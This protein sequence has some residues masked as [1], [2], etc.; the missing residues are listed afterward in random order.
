[1]EIN[2]LKIGFSLMTFIIVIVGGLINSY[3]KFLPVFII[4]SFRY[5][6]FSYCGK[7]SG[8][9][10]IEVPKRWF[11][12]FYIVSSLLSISS[13]ILMFRIILLGE[14]A[15]YALIR[16]LDLIATSNRKAGVSG[17]ALL[18]ALSLMCLQCCRRLY[19]TTY[20][21]VF[22]NSY[23]NVF[24]Y[25][26]GFIHYI[27]SILAILSEAPSLTPLSFEYKAALSIW[28]VDL[29]MVFGIMVFC[30]AWYHQFVSAK[31]LANLRKNKNGS[32]VTL[33]HG[34]PKGDL[35][36]VVSS[37]SQLC[38]VLI[39][40]ALAVIL[41]GNTAWPF[42]VVWV[43]SNQMETALLSHWWYQ[44]EFKDYPKERRAIVPLLL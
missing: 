11:Q 27:G 32:V 36:E 37:P 19:E 20:V 1:M 40:L 35:F 15:P 34:L 42:V 10:P 2:L 31:I 24:H 30:W 3:E 39:Y 6:K 16:F 4:E 8:L 38:E 25:L 7:E 44:A 9:K 43:L 23:M 29:F 13:L 33:K 41:R 17:T 26:V 28:D 21:S 5:G 22:S 14:E 12:H 18:I